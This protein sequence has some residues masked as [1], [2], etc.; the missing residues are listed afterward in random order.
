[1]RAINY[2]LVVDKIKEEPKKIAGLIITEMTDEEGRY[3]K[4][5][6]ISTGNLVEGVKDGDTIAYDKHAGHAITQ[7]DKVYFVIK[8][9]DIVLI[10]N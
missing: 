3:S 5:K 1:M 6:V 9:S 4:A 7:D 10:D 2:Y 8:V